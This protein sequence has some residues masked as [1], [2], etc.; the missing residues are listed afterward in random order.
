MRFEVLSELTFGQFDFQVVYVSAHVHTEVDRTEHIDIVVK[1][2]VRIMPPAECNHV[3][4]HLY[5]ERIDINL[6]LIDGDLGINGVD[7]VFRLFLETQQL[8]NL[9][10]GLSVQHHEILRS[11]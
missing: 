3:V 4:V 9:V 11:Q 6:I 1:S 8:G 7:L 5:A 2:H 10:E